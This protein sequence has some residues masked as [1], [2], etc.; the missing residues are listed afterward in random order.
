MLAV[1]QNNDQNAEVAVNQ[2]QIE[3]G[4][5]DQLVKQYPVYKRSLSKHAIDCRQIAA[6]IQK[7]INKQTPEMFSTSVRTA[8][9]FLAEGRRLRLKLRMSLLQQE[10]TGL[11]LEASRW[12]TLE[13][14]FKSLAEECRQLISTCKDSISS[15][16][17][18]AIEESL[19]KATAL[20]EKSISLRRQQQFERR[21]DVTARLAE[22][23]EQ[24]KE[25][26]EQLQQKVQ[27]DPELK[28][29]YTDLSQHCLEA[30]KQLQQKAEQASINQIEKAIAAT[31]HF[32]ARLEISQVK[33]EL[34][35]QPFDQEATLDQEENKV[36]SIR[37]F[38]A[39]EIEGVE[40]EDF[41]EEEFYAN[42]ASAA[43]PGLQEKYEH[44][45]ERET[46]VKRRA[47]FF[48]SITIGFIALMS[49]VL[50]KMLKLMER[51]F[52]LVVVAL[53]IV[54]FV[55]VL[56][57]LSGSGFSSIGLL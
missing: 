49:G 55:F 18:S 54:V 46:N 57:Y 24:L 3:A 34:S 43:I 45:Q 15:G 4:H 42:S 50:H 47:G 21:Q 12:P 37:E 8:N 11:E 56:T 28:N 1:K 33:A 40:D 35:E 51:V 44:Q 2:L 36:T 20:N 41:Q 48:K 17:S 13:S 39:S 16:S 32:L 23:I 14:G 19:I 26:A 10:A 22:K 27:A 52:M 31:A 53:V 29:K 6:N 25:Q 5:F 30:A 7:K 9:V 38:T